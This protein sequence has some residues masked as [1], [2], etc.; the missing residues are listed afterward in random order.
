[1]GARERSAQ[2]LVVV[3]SE[4]AAF[5]VIHDFDARARHGGVYDTPLLA[6]RVP[7]LVCG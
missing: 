1:M 7:Q 2:Q 6:E 4:G 5:D 3:A